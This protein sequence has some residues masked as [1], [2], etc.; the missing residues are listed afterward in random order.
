MTKEEKKM[1]PKHIEDLST[2]QADAAFQ[3]S[4]V[5]QLHKIEPQLQYAK[6]SGSIYGIPLSVSSVA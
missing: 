1:P 4:C 5:N 2:R 3:Q 6:V